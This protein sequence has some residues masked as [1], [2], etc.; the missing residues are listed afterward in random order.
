MFKH[1]I[2]NRS[3][4]FE[5]RRLSIFGYEDFSPGFGGFWWTKSFRS[6]SKKYATLEEAKADFHHRDKVVFP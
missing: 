1:I 2:L 4:S 3:G 5:I 6:Q